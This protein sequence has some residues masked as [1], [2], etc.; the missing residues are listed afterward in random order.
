MEPQPAPN[1]PRYPIGKFQAP[2]A[3]TRQFRN[4]CI[5]VIGGAADELRKA[6]ATL[7]NSQLDTPY[8]DGGW[9]V[10]QVIHHIADSHMNSFVRFKLAL[11]EDN[12]T[13]KPYH[14]GAWAGTADSAA[15][16]VEP[17]L[18][19]IDALHQRWAA[20]LRSMT[21]EQYARTFVHPERS[22]AIPLDLTLAIYAWHC[23]HHLAH[24][25]ALKQRSGWK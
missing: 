11:T 13:I 2:E 23:R 1:D 22:G 7:D 24:I 25:T 19:L 9:T 15:M 5:Q 3:I 21:D 8:R 17:S 20:L 6:V 18:Q 14:E 4:E 12:P 10:R 16:P